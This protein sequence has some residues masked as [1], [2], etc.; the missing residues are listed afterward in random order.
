MTEH[1]RDLLIEIG[2][3]ELPPAALETL[4][5]ALTE[6][7]Q[8]GL[9]EAAIAG[10]A[11]QTYATPRRLG[12]LVRQ[13]PVTQPT[14]TIE[15]R[16]PA[17]DKA[18]DAEG[19]PT[20][21][22]LGFARSCG[23]D[24][25]ELDRMETPKGTWLVFRKQAPGQASAAL[26]PDI[27]TEA[28]S[29]LPIPKRMRW[30][31]SEAEFVR[32]VHWLVLLFGDEVIPA[33][34]LD[35]TAGRHSY[36]HRFHHPGTIAIDAPATYAHQLRET[37]WV[38][39]ELAERHETIRQQVAAAAAELG[40]QPLLDEALLAEVT[41][42]VEWPVPITGH[43]DARFLKVPQ[44]ALIL[45]MQQHQK[46]FPVVDANGQLLPHFIT[47]S[48][49]ASRAPEQVRLG[50]ERVIR[51]RLADA[52]FFWNQD[53][54]RSLAS[55]IDDL[56]AML[57]QQK[58]GT[59]RVKSERVAQLAETIAAQL[60]VDP[61]QARRAAL[62]AKCDLLTD[63]VFEFTELQGIMGRYYALH[64]GEP[65]EVAAAMAEH[66]LPRQAGDTLPSTGV[67]RCLAL[68]DKLDTLVGIFAIGQ[69][70]TGVKDPFGLRR[71]ALGVLRILIEQRLDL[72]LEALLQAAATGLAGQ[73][74]AD[75]APVEVFDYCMD[76]LRGYYHERGIAHDRIEAVLARRPTR[77]FDIDRRLQAV[78][79]FLDLPEAASLAAANKRIHNILKKTDADVPNTV[80]SA[81]LQEPAEQ[82]LHDQVTARHAPVTAQLVAGNYQTAMTQLAGLRDA[83][84][85]FFDTVLVM[86]EDPNLQRNRLA[87]L[88]QL[89]SLFLGTADLSK[90]Q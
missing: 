40:G 81:L 89:Q 32:P 1:A 15:R 72:D 46:Y 90:L 87:L 54:K 7:V 30:G 88:G 44:E 13:V 27:L 17:L 70:P 55:R 42:L 76:R 25:A 29:K 33:E 26:I 16:G 18:F 10:N 69:R 45:T 84:D 39:A 68:A 64:D 35:V 43:F 20:K 37:G 14:Q 2:T 47:I 65:V 19:Q 83:V 36:G 86:A 49:I 82:A 60:K 74:D 63:M 11:Y 31:T 61:A 12:L 6:Q 57:F 78:Q 51:P 24:V 41:A 21:A 4:A 5:N 52:E 67:G 23:V 9:A 28:I 75:H 38:M 77:P 53:R 3:E 80:D 71:A 62:L 8:T 56:E 22:V 59:L 66:Y 50:N 58:L 48:N 73:V 34:L 79:A 85:Q